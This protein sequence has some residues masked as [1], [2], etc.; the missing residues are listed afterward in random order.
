MIT[1][2]CSAAHAPKLSRLLPASRTGVLCVQHPTTAARPAP[3]CQVFI[4]SISGIPRNTSFLP[5][6]VTSCNFA[7]LRRS[8]KGEKVFSVV[9]RG[10]SWTKKVF[11]VVLRGPPVFSVVLRGPSWTKKGVL[12]GPSWPFVDKKGVLSGPSWPSVDKKVFSVVL[13]GPPWSVLSGPSWP[14]VDKKGVLC[15]PPWP[16]VDKKGV[17]CGP[18][19][20]SVDK[21]RFSPLRGRPAPSRIDQITTVQSSVQTN[22]NEPCYNARHLLWTLV[23]AHTTLLRALV[24]S[25]RPSP[26]PKIPP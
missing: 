22:L 26:I 5:F 18:P 7:T 13:R 6:R 2:C 1:N 15:G 9:F 16:S 24:S 10:P 17:L 20:P 3:G 23:I 4:L 25:R 21:I 8:R 14:F 11:S 12:S 19:W